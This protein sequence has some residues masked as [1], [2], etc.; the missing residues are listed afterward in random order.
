MV[1]DGEFFSNFSC[2]FKFDDFFFFKILFK[3]LNI[4]P[5]INQ[6]QVSSDEVYIHVS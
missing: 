2:L 6:H 5:G 4:T 3:S 1:A